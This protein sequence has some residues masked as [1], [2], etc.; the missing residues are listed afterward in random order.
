MNNQDKHRSLHVALGQVSNVAFGIPRA[1][2]TRHRGLALDVM[3]LGRSAITTETPLVFVI[4]NRVIPD[5]VKMQFKPTIQTVFS[6]DSDGVAGLPVGGVLTDILPRA[7]KVVDEL[8]H[9]FVQADTP[10]N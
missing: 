4:A 8:T 5:E 3:S 2:G 6:D 1:I 10:N 7:S 9:Q